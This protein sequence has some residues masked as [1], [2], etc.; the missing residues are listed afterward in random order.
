[1]YQLQHIIH[2]VPD[3]LC[4]HVGNVHGKG[5]ILIDRHGGD[6]PEVL[7]D[8]THLPAQIG[9]LAAPQPCHIL[10]VHKNLALTGQHFPQDQLEQGGF[11]C[12]GVTYQENEL[13]RV[14]MQADI[15]QRETSAPLVLHRN[16]F[17]IN[18][19]RIAPYSL[20]AVGCTLGCCGNFA[21]KTG[22]HTGAAGLYA[23]LKQSARAFFSTWPG[24]WTDTF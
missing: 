7:K 4:T 19:E 16:V 10:A 5:H 17:K 12:T 2:P 24:C 11:A 13:A 9:H 21:A 3:L 18:H 8:D 22:W 20:G 1:M 23:P 15:L 6:Q 14:H